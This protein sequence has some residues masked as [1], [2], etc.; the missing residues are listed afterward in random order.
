MCTHDNLN[1]DSQ[2]SLCVLKSCHLSRLCWY[3]FLSFVGYNQSTNESFSVEKKEHSRKDLYRDL[4]WSI[5]VTPFPV[6][7]LKFNV[8]VY[9]QIRNLVI[10]YKT[11][12]KKY[13]YHSTG[14]ILKS[15]I[16][17]VETEV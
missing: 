16:K 8:V 10:K 15:N 2:Q 13:I 14:T 17:M 12:A 5:C 3:L 1:C 7:D 6:L 11:K 9:W 4:S